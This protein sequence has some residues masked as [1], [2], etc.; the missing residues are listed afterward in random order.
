MIQNL[1]EKYNIDK[2][3]SIIGINSND[4]VPHVQTLKYNSDDSIKLIELDANL[5]RAI[6][7]G[8]NLVIRGEYEDSLILCTDNKTFEL[9]E[10]ETTNSLLI[11]SNGLAN[12]ELLTNP[13]LENNLKIE[14][15]THNYIEPCL[16]KPNFLKLKESLEPTAYRGPTYEI[17][18]IDFFKYSMK[19]LKN[20]IQAS[21][22]EILKALYELNA[23]I[24]NGFY[25]IIENTYFN[26]IVNHILSLI[27]ENSWSYKNVYLN[28]TLYTLEELFPREVVEFVF[29]SMMKKLLTTNPSNIIN[30][31]D[32]V[33]ELDEIKICRFFAED[34]LKNTI[35][36]DFKDF[37]NIWKLS[38]PKGIKTHMTYLE[39]LAIVLIENNKKIIKF[40]PEASLP[41]NTKERLNSLFKIK[42]KWSL[43]ELK[44]YFKG[45]LEN[46]SDN[47][48][49]SKSDDNSILGTLLNKFARKIIMPNT[50]DDSNDKVYYCSKY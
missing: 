11:I 19:D 1:D 3:A 36:F 16:I 35:K 4:I 13:P 21:D 22:Q 28:E 42:E 7:D 24:I 25:R 18:L 38:V 20:F 47:E 46:I 23:T 29:K 9:K 31:N 15:L 34:I 43:T 45:F 14:H 2:I 26:Q 12:E 39:G 50:G 27:E 33:Y 40:L 30:S 37:L 48:N 6:Q 17:E 32:D 49:P 8:Q 10:A 44:M 41:Q 5:M